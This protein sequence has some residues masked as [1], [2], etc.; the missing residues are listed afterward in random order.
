MVEIILGC[1]NLDIALQHAKPPV[2][3]IDSPENV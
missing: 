3:A 2:P 1:L